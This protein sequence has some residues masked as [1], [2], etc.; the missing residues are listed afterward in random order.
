MPAKT[1]LDERACKQTHYKGERER[2]E[3]RAPTMRE[4]ETG[5]R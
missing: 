3:P 2:R 5:A 1:G 4:A